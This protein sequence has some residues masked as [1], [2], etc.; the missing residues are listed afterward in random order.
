MPHWVSS[1]S[2]YRVGSSIGNLTS[3]PLAG[4]RRRSERAVAKEEQEQTFEADVSLITIA[5]PEMRTA[6]EP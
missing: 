4:L 1:L 2:T 3:M 5:R 6:Q